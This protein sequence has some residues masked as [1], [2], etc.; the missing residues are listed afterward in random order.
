MKVRTRVYVGD[1]MVEVS[2]PKPLSARTS[3]DAANAIA[4]AL[5]PELYTRYRKSRKLMLNAKQRR[6]SKRYFW[7]LLGSA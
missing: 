4:R 3:A 2:R 7:K 5:G 1:R 6:E